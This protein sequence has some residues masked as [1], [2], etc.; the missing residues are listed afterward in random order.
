MRR[1][2]TRGP[3]ISRVGRNEREIGMLYEVVRET[4]RGEIRKAFWR[5]EKRG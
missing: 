4:H 1:T 3:Q 5:M 2:H